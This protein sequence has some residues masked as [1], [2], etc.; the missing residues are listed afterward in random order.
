MEVGLDPCFLPQEAQF[1]L[2]GVWSAHQHPVAPGPKEAGPWWQCH[3]GRCPRSRRCPHTAPGIF[4]FYPKL[5]SL[6]GF[7][8]NENEEEE[9]P[10]GGVLCPGRALGWLR[11]REEKER[12]W[13][14]M[15]GSQP[16][17]RVAGN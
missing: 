8:A 9:V 15:E 2:A 1:R 16:E 10:G 11:R 7:Q 4:P 14:E 6:P 12:A 13:R 3:Q 17:P 5:L